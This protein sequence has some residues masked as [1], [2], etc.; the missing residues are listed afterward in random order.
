MGNQSLCICL[1]NTN[2]NENSNIK[3]PEIDSNTQI[4]DK[5]KININQKEHIKRKKINQKKL[6]I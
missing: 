1:R 4:V 2:T 3:V 5:N 6:N